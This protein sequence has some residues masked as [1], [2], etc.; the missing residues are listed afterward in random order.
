MSLMLLHLTACSHWFLQSR[1]SI[2]QSSHSQHPLTIYL[3]VCLSAANALLFIWFIRIEFQ[4]NWVLK[5]DFVTNGK[6]GKLFDRNGIGMRKT[7][8]YAIR[9]N[10]H[11]QPLTDNV[12]IPSFVLVFV[13]N[14]QINMDANVSQDSFL[15]HFSFYFEKPSSGV[16]KNTTQYFQWQQSWR[17]ITRVA[18]LGFWSTPFFV[19]SMPIASSIETQT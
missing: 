13:W 16:W 10:A 17:S 2:P 7:M 3:S 5:K 15:F 18:P 6:V 9:H 14:V 8:R 4:V 1:L 19:H 12:P 11:T